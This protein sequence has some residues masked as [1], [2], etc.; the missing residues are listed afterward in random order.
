V[1]QAE[2]VYVLFHNDI[3]AHFWKDCGTVQKYFSQETNQLL[4]KRLY[5]VRLVQT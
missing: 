5:C 2:S 1:I 3:S 4:P